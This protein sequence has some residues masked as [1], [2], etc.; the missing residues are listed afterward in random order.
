M[1]VTVIGLPAA[2]AELSPVRLQKGIG[3]VVMAVAL[4]SQDRIARYPPQ[5]H[6]K[7][8]FKSEKQRRYFFWALHSGA[9]HVPYIRGGPGSQ[10]LGRRWHIIRRSATEAVLEN[11]A[12]YADLVHGATTQS[13]YHAASGWLTDEGVADRIQSDGTIDRIAGQVFARL[14][15]G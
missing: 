10:T 6:G 8:P 5:R 13:S 12:S 2:L 4:E 3:D 15:V 14:Y 1:S 7:Q 9:I 11:L